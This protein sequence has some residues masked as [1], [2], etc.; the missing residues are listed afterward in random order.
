[1]AGLPELSPAHCAR[2]CIALSVKQLWPESVRWL[3]RPPL[4]SKSQAEGLGSQEALGLLVCQ[5]C[6]QGSQHLLSLFF[7]DPH[8]E[9]E[10]SSPSII[11]KGHPVT[12]PQTQLQDVLLSWLASKKKKKKTNSWELFFSI[13]K[14]ISAY[15]TEPREWM[16]SPWEEMFHFATKTWQQAA[17]NLIPSF[18]L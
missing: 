9:N 2:N 7:T 15:Y 8:L 13:K 10:R 17:E 11:N 5:V 12:P 4:T 16:M 14:K 3:Y 1:M 6:T 18:C